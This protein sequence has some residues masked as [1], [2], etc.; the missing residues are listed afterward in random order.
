MFSYNIFIYINMFS[1]TQQCN[2]HKMILIH[3]H[4]KY[5]RYHLQHLRIIKIYKSMP[6]TF[7]SCSLL[8][9]TYD[10]VKVIILW[11]WMVVAERKDSYIKQWCHTDADGYLITGQHRKDFH[12]STV[13]AISLY[14]YS[15]YT[16]ITLNRLY[17]YHLLLYKNMT[18]L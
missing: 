5:Q 16:I 18:T 17:T 1:F 9:K 3:V 13:F 14:S 4:I 10:T 8:T 11:D 12:N 15:K 7:Y 2:S 6:D